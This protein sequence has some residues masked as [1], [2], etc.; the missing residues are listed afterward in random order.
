MNPTWLAFRRL[1]PVWLPAVALAIGSIAFFV[2]QSSGSVGRAAQ[3]EDRIDELEDRIARLERIRELAAAEREHVIE[4]DERFRHLY[5]EVFGSLENRLVAILREIGR[6][7]AEAGLRPESYSYA[8]ATDRQMGQIRFTTG[9]AVDGEYSQIRRLLAGL[10]ASEEFLIVED[11]A[12]T[13]DEMGST[14]SLSIVLRVA[15]YLAEADREQL[16]R[17]TGGLAAVEG[18]GG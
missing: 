13:G 12:F 9:F 7:A 6:A 2:W 14:R 5:E 8:A 4:L 15:T 18:A 11:I 10:Q 1:L 16:R 17:L 3:I